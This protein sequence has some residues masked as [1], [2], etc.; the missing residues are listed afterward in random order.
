MFVN[1][2]FGLATTPQLTV[3]AEAVLDTGERQTVFVDLGGGYL[4]PRAVV[5]GERFGERVSITRGLSAGE[6]V[7]ASGVFLIDSESQLKAAAGGVG[8]PAHEGHK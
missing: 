4:E 1:V 3:P 8:T 5:V 6:R 7:V 2:E